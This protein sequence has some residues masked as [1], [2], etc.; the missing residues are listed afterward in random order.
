MNIVKNEKEQIYQFIIDKNGKSVRGRT[1]VKSRLT[2]FR[3]SL[4]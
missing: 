1:K 3:S 4:K 2:T